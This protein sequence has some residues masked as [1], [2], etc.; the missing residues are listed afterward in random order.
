ML[1]EHLPQAYMFYNLIFMVSLMWS[2]AMRDSI[3]SIHT[4]S[5]N[6]YPINF[7]NSIFFQAA[8][9][10]FSSIFFDF[11]IIISYF[12]HATVWSIIFAIFNLVA[13]PFS[14]LLLHKEV[15]DRGGDF[16]MVAP[17][18]TNNANG[19]RTPRSY[20]DI[21]SPRQGGQSLPSF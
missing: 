21:D 12:G 5:V 6:N 19:S 13:R 8:A 16:V 1:S 3:D 15:V 4:V 17:L 20:Q 9:I 2:V 11:V 14:L 18:P 10:N 7:V